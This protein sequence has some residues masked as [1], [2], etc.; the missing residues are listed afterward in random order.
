MANVARSLER[1]KTSGSNFDELTKTV[2]G[3]IS[4]SPV[5]FDQPW[6]LLSLS[7]LA[8]GD[9]SG[10]IATGNLSFERSVALPLRATAV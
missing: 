3:M 8:A 10:K 1:F 6:G 5:R 7:L 2:S 4:R 9:R